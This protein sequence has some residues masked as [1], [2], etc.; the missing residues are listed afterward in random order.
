MNLA[1]NRARLRTLLALCLLLPL[2]APAAPVGRLDRIKST[3]KITVAYAENAVPF[4]F[5]NKEGQPDGYSI[6]LCKRVLAG[7]QAQLKLQKL[8]VTWVAATTP[9]RLK[10]VAA[11]KADLECGI[12]S[13]TLKREEQVGFSMTVFVDGAGVVVPKDSPIVTLPGLD[14]RK[15]AVVHGT[16]TEQRLRD[17]LKERGIAGVLMPVED[18]KTALEM[19]DRGEAQAYAGDRAVLVGQVLTTKTKTPDWRLLEADISYEPYAFALARGDP[20]LQLAVDRALAAEFR[21]GRI[22]D[23]YGRWFGRFGKPQPLLRALFVLNQIPE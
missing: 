23:V 14:G 10:M 9:E 15:I 17:V 13:H 2:A 18:R 21:S 4:S 7:I 6:E 3:G 11:G 19:V 5:K 20:A 22:E 8:D 16:T 12:T 1:E